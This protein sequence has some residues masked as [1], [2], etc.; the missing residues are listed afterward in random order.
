MSITTRLVTIDNYD[1]IFALWNSTEQSKRALNPVDD[2]RE[3]I[4]GM[5]VKK[6]E[7][8]FVFECAENSRPFYLPKDGSLK[9][10]NVRNNIE[11][12]KYFPFYD[13]EY[14]LDVT[15]QKEL[16]PETTSMKEGLV[17]S[18]EWYRNNKD[19]VTRKNFIEYMDE[20]LAK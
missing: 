1:G 12:R 20:Y 10:K 6:A 19:A 13:Y 5:L 2:S 18:Y 15:I 4:A 9:I 17:K 3:G 7:E 11:Q 8:A 16:L 14:K